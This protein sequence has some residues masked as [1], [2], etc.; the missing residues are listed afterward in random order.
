M[1]EI[2]LLGEVLAEKFLDANDKWRGGDAKTGFHSS[3]GARPQVSSEQVTL[4]P[5]RQMAYEYSHGTGMEAAGPQS[6]EPNL[7][8]G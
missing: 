1:K 6:H 3:K 5:E 7:I 4:K 8:M 2:V